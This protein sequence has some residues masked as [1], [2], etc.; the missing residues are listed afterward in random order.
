MASTDRPPR[1]SRNRCIGH[2]DVVARRSPATVGSR[3]RLDH[4]AC[5]G[6]TASAQFAG[7]AA[8]LPHFWSN[9]ATRA[10]PAEAWAEA[11]CPAQCIVI[12]GEPGADGSRRRS[13][14]H[15]YDQMHLLR[16]CARRPARSMPSS[17]GQSCGF[18]AEESEELFYNKAKLLA[19][20]DRLG[21]ADRAKLSPPISHIADGGS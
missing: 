19:N 17:W 9:A 8:F 14:R 6:R 12:E 4:D 18:A 2:V 11:V 5:A 16:V 1:T 15:R 10:S 20:R 21:A 7:D 3:A 13:L